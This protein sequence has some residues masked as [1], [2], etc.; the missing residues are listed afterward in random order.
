MKG[1]EEHWKQLKLSIE[2]EIDIVVNEG[3]LLQELWN[4][5]N[6]LI[7]KVHTDR[8]IS[9]VVLQTTMTKVW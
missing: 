6:N 7:A 5:D 9:K 2:E 1:L 8:Y 4:G 3:A